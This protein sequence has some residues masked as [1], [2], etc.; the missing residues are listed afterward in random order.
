VF[1]FAAKGQLALPETTLATIL[2]D[3]Q[4]YDARGKLNA[5][6]RRL[7]GDFRYT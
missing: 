3:F 5:A 7:V 1:S 4:L 6:G 2:A